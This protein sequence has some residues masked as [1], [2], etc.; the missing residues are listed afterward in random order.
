MTLRRWVG[1]PMPGLALVA[2]L[3]AC[4]SGCGS[5]N[6]N[7]AFNGSALRP[8]RTASPRAT[9]RSAKPS[10]SP[11]ASASS[12]PASAS[13]AADTGICSWPAD[14]Q[15]AAQLSA[16]I[17]QI[18]QASDLTMDMAATDPG[19][20][21]SCALRGDDDSHSASIVKVIILAA[22]LYENQPDP[23]LS[24]SNAALANQMITQ[25]SDTAASALWSEVGMNDLQ[26]FLTAAGMDHTY[27]GQDG[28]W[29]LTEVNP[30]DELRLLQVLDTPN[31]VLDTA[32]RDYILTLMRE[33][34]PSEH[35][36]VSAG[37]PSGDTVYLKNGWLP[38]PTLWVIN[39]IGDI[40]TPK[41]DYSMAILTHG[42]PSMPY[43][44][45]RVEMIATL[46]N[47]ALASH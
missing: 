43:G 19:Q 21:L 10:P 11:S 37:V 46:I 28:Y 20:G 17:T 15:A 13:P 6:F 44:I 26:E 35:W 3:A 45:T 27:L 38:D 39:S 22:L 18:A 47:Q 16:Q 5:G 40:A 4:V 33:V 41:G 23:D 29:G 34:I 8:T 36:G 7:A 1:W 24:P 14:P 32:C 2:V 25:S 42:G 30:E 12:P 31:S 9:R